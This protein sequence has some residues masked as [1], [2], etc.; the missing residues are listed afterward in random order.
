MYDANV[1]DNFRHL[2]YPK[3]ILLVTLMDSLII[4]NIDGIDKPRYEHDGMST[5][6]WINDVKVFGEAGVYSME[7][8]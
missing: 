6:K 7:T 2:L 1:P 8:N 3:A 5:P 4:V